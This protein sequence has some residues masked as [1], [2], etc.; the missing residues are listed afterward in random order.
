MNDLERYENVIPRPLSL[1]HRKKRARRPRNRAELERA[2]RAESPKLL[3]LALQ[4]GILPPAEDNDDS[5][6]R[7]GRRTSI[8]KEAPDV[9]EV[10]KDRS[11][12]AEAAQTIAN[13][14]RISKNTIDSTDCATDVRTEAEK[15]FD[16]I[17]KQRELDRLRALAALSNKDQVEIFNES[18]AK[19]PEHF[20]LFKVSH[21]K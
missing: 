13:E 16:E 6:D 8:S 18:L 12:R 4:R 5:A 10:P 3:E 20:D 9:L 1:K 21:T 15:Q 11:S 7:D 19:Q 17:A 2:L 14:Q